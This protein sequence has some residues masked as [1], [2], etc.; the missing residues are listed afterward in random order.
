M[1]RCESS[2]VTD[3]TS[4]L[5]IDVT[6][7]RAHNVLKGICCHIRHNPGR[8]GC[9]TPERPGRALAGPLSPC[10]L[11]GLSTGGTVATSQSSN[12][13]RFGLTSE[14][15]PVES[16]THPGCHRVAP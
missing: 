7:A 13:A 4:G 15:S 3:V 14:N 8:G 11:W 16:W 10:T 12:G 5:L 9:K 2:S 1:N 6:R